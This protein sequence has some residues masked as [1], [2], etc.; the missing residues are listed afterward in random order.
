LK[1][2]KRLE[3]QPKGDCKTLKECKIGGLWGGVRWKGVMDIIHQDELT[4]GEQV[5]SSTKLFIFLQT[6]HHL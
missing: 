3:G 2:C 6:G 5:P 1:E 4:E